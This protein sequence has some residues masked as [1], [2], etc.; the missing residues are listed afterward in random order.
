MTMTIEPSPA[1]GEAPSTEDEVAA[2]VGA[3]AERLLMT[4]LAGFEAMTIALGRDLGLYAVLGSREASTAVELAEAAAIAPRYAQEWLEQQAAAGWIQVTAPGAD[5]DD[6]DARRFGLSVAAQECLTRPESLA[7][8]GPLFDFL[9]SMA[10]VYPALRSAFRSGAGVA[11]ADYCVHDAQADFNRPAFL[12][13]LASDWLPAI[14]GL[15]ERLRRPGARIAEIGCGEGWAAVAMAR[16]FPEVHVDG[17]DVDDASVAAARRHAAES[18]VAERVRFEVSDVTADMLPEGA[19]AA[20]YD[21]VCAFEMIHDLARPV[22]AL[23]TMRRLAAP[24]ATVLVVDEKVGEHFEANTENPLERMFYAASV[25]HCLPVGLSGT[26]SSGTG[27]VMR[28]AVLERYAT[29]A[30]F[31]AVHIVPIDFDVFRFYQLIA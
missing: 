30:G 21:L 12:N 6:G 4:G 5:V 27:A 25:L 31:S 16:A 2:Q 23:A 7:S 15:T 9:P 3:Y 17:F 20:G 14:P 19:V 26:D 1:P 13:L 18:G 28:P 8:V 22:A 29:A 24:E 10:L 11:Y